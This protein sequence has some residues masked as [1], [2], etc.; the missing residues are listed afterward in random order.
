MMTMWQNEEHVRT[1]EASGEAARLMDPFR[2][3]FASPPD[4]VGYPVVFDRE[5]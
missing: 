5:F 2:E 1:Y 3:M 4:I